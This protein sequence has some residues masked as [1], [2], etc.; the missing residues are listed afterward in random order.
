MR[1]LLFDTET[2]GLPAAWNVP[3]TYVENW[4]RIIQMAW[5]VYDID[6]G[7][8]LQRV[9]TLI[10]PDP[11][12]IWDTKAAEIHRIPYKS[13][14][15]HGVSIQTAIGWFRSDCAESDLIVAHNL[16]FD[17]ATLWAE[18]I[19][20]VNVGAGD[21]EPT[22]WWP[23]RELCAMLASTDICRLPSKKQSIGQNSYKWPRLSELFQYLF[24]DEKLPTNLHDAG[25]DVTCL[26]R[27]FLKL[28]RQRL[29]ELPER[30][31]IEWDDVFLVGLLRKII[32]G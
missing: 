17:K 32:R 31:D 15:T 24:P 5:Q 3:Y 4:P 27:C 16:K 22:R 25:E 30:A 12:M 1:V 20:L 11:R 8:C 23:K 6:T 14:K 9:S 18:C 21:L 19:R 2:N 10:K 7:T 13:L 29:V 26:S 28:V